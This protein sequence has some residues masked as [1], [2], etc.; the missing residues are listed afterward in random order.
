MSLPSRIAVLRRRGYREAQ[1]HRRE[2]GAL[3]NFGMARRS[4]SRLSDSGRHFDF[5]DRGAFQLAID[6]R[7][8]LLD[9]LLDVLECFRL[10]GSL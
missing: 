4:L 3:G 7:E 9:C 1:A 2:Q 10:G 5:A 8:V 6:D